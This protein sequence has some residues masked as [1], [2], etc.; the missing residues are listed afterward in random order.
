MTLVLNGTSTS[1]SA[2]AVV[3]DTANTGVYYPATNQVAIATNGTLALI[4]NAS[5][6]VTLGVT[7]G[8]V[9]GSNSAGKEVIYKPI[10][11]TSAPYGTRMIDLFAYYPGFE[12]SNPSATIFA[13]VDAATSTQNGYIAFQTINSNTLSEAFRVNQYGT[14]VLKGASV[15]GGGVG[16]AFPAT[17]VASTDA[18]TLDDYEEG[19]WTPFIGGANTDPTITYTARYGYYVKVGRMLFV[20][21]Y[22]YSNAGMSGGTGNVLLAGL[23]FTCIGG[24]NGAYQFLPIGYNTFNGNNNSGWRFQLNGN[25]TY[26]PIYSAAGGVNLPNSA[27]TVEFSFSGVFETT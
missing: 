5:Q 16:V 8:S 4:V 17:Q 7:G 25:L 9:S 6:Q 11:T 13:G 26:G 23:P 3:G 2:P 10:D 15:N 21:G 19:T 12:N 1:A 22:I 14:A 27:S 24:S 18:N 20:S